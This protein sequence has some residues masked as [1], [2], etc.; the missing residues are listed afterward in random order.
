[1][2]GAS[3]TGPASLPPLREDLKLISA[4]SNRDGSPAWMIHD[5][6]SNRFFR[7]G[8]LEFE[9]LSRWSLREPAALLASLNRQT[10][11]DASPEELADFCAFLEQHQLVRAS[12]ATRVRALVR[13]HEKARESTLRWLLHNYLF[14]R[15]PLV[16]PQRFL[17]ATAPALAFLQT[18]G[19]ALITIACTLLGLALAARQWDTFVHTFQDFMTPG[20]LLGYA[21]ALTFAKTLHELGHAYVA[22]RHGVRVAH[23]GVA[24]LVLWPMLYT[25]TGESWKL[26]DRRK[27]FAI[28]GAG[29]A[30]E[31]AIAGFATLAWSLAPE[32]AW[33]SAFFFLA[34]TSWVITLA[35]NA[36]PFMRFDGYFLLSDALDLPNLH[37]RAF[38]VARSALRR[39][40]LGWDEPDPEHFEPGLRRFLI[41]F[42]WATG[43]YRLIVFAGIAFAVYHFFFKAL[44]LFL[45]AVEIAWFILR[46]I[47][48]ELGQWIAAPRR[49]Q[50]GHVARTLLGLIALLAVFAIP[51]RTTVR[52]E[53][54]AHAEHQQVVYSPVPARVLRVAA[55]GDYAAGAPLVEL[56]S[57]D[58]RSR[59]RQSRIAV[60]ALALQLDQSVGRAEGLERRAVLAEQLGRQRADLHAQQAEIAR[61]ELRAAF[62]GR[63]QDLDRAIGPGT[64]VNPQQ[65]IA[66]LVDPGGWVVDALVEQDALGRFEVG[67]KARFHRRGD[68]GPALTG[69]VEAIDTTRLQGMPHAMLAT[70]HGGH[71]AAVRQ[72]SGALAPRDAL[73]RVRVRLDDAPIGLRQA[74]GSVAIDARSRSMLLDGLR[75]L[76]AVLLRES[77][78]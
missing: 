69:V 5:P 56:D 33:R 24:F 14:F 23:M 46:P 6:V 61:L 60:D 19:F 36:S 45:F 51:W 11:L 57:P 47:W 4:A 32:G 77:G 65:P 53:G 68:A 42:A 78:F 1:M 43:V 17:A 50:A 54:W 55:A 44:G 74:P 63:L 10:P 28:A 38:A 26:A 12:D 22:T 31:L 7:I 71:V 20:G 27:R 3:G 8:W 48:G 62:A 59:A 39:T 52:A 35:I 2:P 58:T 34:T 30:T 13:M 49:A 16:R 64:W 41:G 25:D 21:L 40:A 72:P 73:Y 37:Q 75:R 70:E 76:A 66:I 18:R 15:L 29:I 9:C 67:A